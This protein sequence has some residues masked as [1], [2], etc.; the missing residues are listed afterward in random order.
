MVSICDSSGT[1]KGLLGPA[2]RSFPVTGGVL[3]VLEQGRV[4]LSRADSGLGPI[5]WKSRSCQQSLVMTG[6]T[7]RA[8]SS[9]LPYHTIGSRFNMWSRS[10]SVK[11]VLGHLE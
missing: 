3:V 4:S 11:Y 10:P 5:D 2:A 7:G 8:T 6:G 9:H 1:R